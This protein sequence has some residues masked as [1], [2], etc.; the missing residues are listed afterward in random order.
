MPVFLSVTLSVCVCEERERERPKTER[1]RASESRLV[2]QKDQR[3]VNGLSHTVW[4]CS[5]LHLKRD[6]QRHNQPLTSESHQ[7][8]RTLVNLCTC[9]L[10]IDQHALQASDTRSL[11]RNQI[12]SLS[13]SLSLLIQLTT[14]TFA[15]TNT[16]SMHVVQEGKINK[17]TLCRRNCLV[18]RID[19]CNISNRHTHTHT[20]A[21]L[22][23]V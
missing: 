18:P 19:Q 12:V 9:V 13:L 6:T 11:P 5:S 7:A 15:H 17:Y 3:P 8:S 20:E 16:H 21:A 4:P 2:E 22:D 1:K 10:R 23:T 14:R